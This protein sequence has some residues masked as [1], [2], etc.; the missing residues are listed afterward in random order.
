ML[1]WTLKRDSGPVRKEHFIQASSEELLR[2]KVLKKN[3]ITHKICSQMYTVW[4]TCPLDITQLN[5]QVLY[6]ATA[7]FSQVFH[8]PG[9]V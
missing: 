6:T 1:G 2:R 3:Y 9:F 4:L 8:F 7:T 5:V